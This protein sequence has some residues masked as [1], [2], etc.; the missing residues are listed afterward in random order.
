MTPRGWGIYGTSSRTARPGFLERRMGEES[1]GAQRQRAADRLSRG[2]CSEC[3]RP[4]AVAAVEAGE[5]RLLCVC[6]W[7]TVVKRG[8]RAYRVAIVKAAQP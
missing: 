2:C 7:R 1:L 3:G 5:A 4:L 6:G 8:S